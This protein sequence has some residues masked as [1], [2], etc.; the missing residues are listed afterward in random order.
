MNCYIGY[1]N[2]S[3]IVTRFH[4]PFSQGMNKTS[5]HTVTAIL[6]L[7][8]ATLGTGCLQMA[9]SSINNTAN[10]KRASLDAECKQNMS[11]WCVVQ[12][13]LVEEQRANDI[14]DATMRHQMAAQQIANSFRQPRR[15]EY[16]CRPTGFGSVRCRER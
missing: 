13:R 12:Y 1:L 3:Y 5:L 9:Q 16:E 6:A 11:D 14:A 10:A 15:S 2:Y 7:T 4:Y 8:M